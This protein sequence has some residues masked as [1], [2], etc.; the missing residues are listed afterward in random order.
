MVQRRPDISGA[1]GD[2]GSGAE[3]PQILCGEQVLG[4]NRPDYRL[5]ARSAISETK[6]LEDQELL[7]P[8]YRLIPQAS[9]AMAALGSRLASHEEYRRLVTR[10]LGM[11]PTNLNKLWPPLATRLNSARL[12]GRNRVRDRLRFPDQIEVSG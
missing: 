1:G 11:D 6:L 7:Y 12:G 10:M 2:P 4:A 3:A 8:G 5:I 9:R